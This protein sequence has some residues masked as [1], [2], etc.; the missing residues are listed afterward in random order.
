MTITH[1][2]S[3]F[4]HRLLTLWW[5]VSYSKRSIPKK[6]KKAKS[7]SWKKNIQY[8]QKRLQAKQQL[9]QQLEE[10]S[11][12]HNLPYNRV[13]IRDQRTRW[14]SCSAQKNI[15]LNWRLA[16]MPKE[17]AEYVIIHELVHTIHMH[18]R[19]TFWSLVESL[20]PHTKQAIQRLKQ[21]GW[22]ILVS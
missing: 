12:K 16:L 6:K 20:C 1:I 10:L 18:H 14:G 2:L 22:A 17:I 9:I 4:L 7:S 5:A 21:H 19:R 13:T 11:S 3:D 8:I 15:S